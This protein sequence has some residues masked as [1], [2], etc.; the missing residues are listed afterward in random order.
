MTLAEA[1]KFIAYSKKM[2]LKHARIGDL[3]V[4]FQDGVV[5]ES[6]HFRKSL[7][8]ATATASVPPALERPAPPP[9]PTLEQI[10][11]H[12]YSTDAEVA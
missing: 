2:G 1:K 3:E 12:I 5:S 7:P 11:Q 9:E 4:T 10:Y 6:R 8:I